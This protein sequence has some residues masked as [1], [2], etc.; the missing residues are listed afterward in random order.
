MVVVNRCGVDVWVRPSSA[1]EPRPDLVADVPSRVAAGATVRLDD[2]VAAGPY[3]PFEAGVV[4]V[5]GQAEVLGEVGP[6]P[7]SEADEAFRAVIEGDL[8]P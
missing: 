5:S 6:L 4:A 3:P 7:Y 1:P 8:C 2:A